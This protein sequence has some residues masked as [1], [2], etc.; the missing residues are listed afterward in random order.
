MSPEKQKNKMNLVK[1]L[2][3]D[4]ERQMIYQQIYVN[5]VIYEDVAK[6]KK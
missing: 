3:V 2:M 5:L 6:K 4:K 1:Q